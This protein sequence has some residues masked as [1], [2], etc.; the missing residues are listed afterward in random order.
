M[1]LDSAGPRGCLVTRAGPLAPDGSCETLD[2]R[3]LLERDPSCLWPSKGAKAALEALLE[4]E[5]TWW[6]YFLPLP[7]LFFRWSAGLAGVACYP[8]SY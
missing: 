4:L 3:V 8:L 7:W 1:E 2:V 5:S 6:L